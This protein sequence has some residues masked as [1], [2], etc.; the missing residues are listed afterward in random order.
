[1]VAMGTLVTVEV[2]TDAA[3]A[4]PEAVTGARDEA[5]HA[6][7]GAASLPGSAQVAGAVQRGLG[8]FGAIEAVASRFDPRSELR[9]LTEQVGQPVPVSPALFEALRFAV[10]LAELTDG[11]FDPTVGDAMQRLGF[12]QHH[13]T[14]E[15]LPA[16]ALE[17]GSWRDVEL[18][19][20]ARTVLLRRRV[21]LDLGAVAKGLAIDLAARELMPLGSYCVEAGGDLY[22]AGLNADGQPWRVGVQ[23]PRE[24]DRL[25]E[26][27][28]VRNAAVCTSGDYE[29]RTAAGHHLVDPRGG[30]VNALASVT[31]VAPSAMVADGLATA[32]FVLGPEA[33]RRLLVEQGVAG[34]L[35][36]P[37]GEQVVVGE[38]ELAR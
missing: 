36:T 9:R 12:D 14:G 25:A 18:D 8:W 30:S 10:A 33:G 3:A 31:V 24:S 1:M 38:P 26:V 4:P 16:A 17:R 35:I 21:L 23:D 28:L 15:R 2:V 19:E 6:L 7:E 22:A 37:A 11:A 27:L 20:A 29:R 5:A 13:V 32:A 34:L